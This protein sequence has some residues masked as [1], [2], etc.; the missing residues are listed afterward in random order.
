M[1][2]VHLINQRKQLTAEQLESPKW[3]NKKH[4]LQAEIMSF[5]EA[6][7]FSLDES[8]STPNKLVIPDNDVGDEDNGWLSS[9]SDDEDDGDGDDDDDNNEEE[10]W[11]ILSHPEDT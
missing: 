4:S 1:S 5:I 9:A 11:E 10:D 6:I 3:A 2:R 7:P 8:L